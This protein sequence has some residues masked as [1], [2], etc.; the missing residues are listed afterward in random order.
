MKYIYSILALA[1]MLSCEM[2]AEVI[3]ATG[4]PDAA[5]TSAE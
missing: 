5:H 2:P 1:F 4:E 3:D